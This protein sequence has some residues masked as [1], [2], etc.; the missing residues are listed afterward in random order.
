MSCVNRVDIARGR[1]PTKIFPHA[2]DTAH[3][4]WR[5]TGKG[6]PYVFWPR[7]W[8][9]RWPHS[10]RIANRGFCLGAWGKWWGLG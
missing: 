4:S 2:Y 9:R 5:G 6:S 8:G 7:I 1:I 10:G 3:F